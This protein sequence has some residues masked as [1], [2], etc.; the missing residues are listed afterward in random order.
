M[1]RTHSLPLVPFLSLW[2]HTFPKQLSEGGVCSG[3]QFEGQS[4]ITG[5]AWQ[6]DPETAGHTTSAVGKQSGWMLV[7]SQLFSFFIFKDIFILCIWVYSRYT[8]QTHQKRVSDP[9]TDGCEPPCGCWDLNSGPLE[10]QSVLL[11][12]KPS[13]QPAFSFWFSPGP[14]PMWPSRLPSS[15]APSKMISEVCFHG[16]LNGV[17][18]TMN[19]T[20]PQN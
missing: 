20:V 16:D 3:S 12:T 4:I 11:T 9:I 10:G 5:K 13:L 6:Q 15:E 19:I 17:R 14:Q 7:P 8:V 18:M 2:L 1:Q